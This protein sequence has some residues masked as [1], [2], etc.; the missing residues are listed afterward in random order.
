MDK[1]ITHKGT[2]LGLTSVFLSSTLSFRRQRG[3]LLTAGQ[4][5]KKGHQNTD[6]HGGQ[7]SHSKPDAY[8]WIQ[9]VIQ[10]TRVNYSSFEKQIR[11]K[12]WRKKY[13]SK[14]V[15]PAVCVWSLKKQDILELGVYQ[16]HTS[17]PQ[18][19]KWVMFQQIK[20]LVKINNPKTRMQ[21]HKHYEQWA[22]FI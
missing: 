4:A 9:H 20:R 8:M 3:Q 17:L 16:T 15:E 18:H 13:D 11:F 5:E 21:V 1:W 10:R 6:T 19:T 7:E 14:S 2:K 12:V 22:I